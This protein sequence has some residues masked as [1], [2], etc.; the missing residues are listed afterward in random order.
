MR[1]KII[2]FFKYLTALKTTNATIE[3]EFDGSYLNHWEGLIDTNNRGVIEL[4][5]NF[6]TYILELCDE[7]SRTIYSDSFEYV[8][9]HS[10][11]YNVFIEINVPK[12]RLTFRSDI[13]VYGEEPSGIA[14][15]FEDEEN[16]HLKEKIYEYLDAH[17]TN[18]ITIGYS[19][20]GDSG[21]LETAYN[22]ETHQPVEYDGDI[23]DICYR[24]LNDFPG[25]EINEGS[26]GEIILNKDGLYVNH[27]WNTEETVTSELDLIL[28]INDLPE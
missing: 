27:L 25:W 22:N 12:K 14:Y 5:T 6:Q 20:S 16:D 7:F 15:E 2:A 19:G 21:G 24:F 1:N 28:D 26:S 8:D 13:I 4:P 11:W 17:N 18:S 23:E 9:S 3:L 10:D